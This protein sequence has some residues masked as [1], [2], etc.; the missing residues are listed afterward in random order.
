MSRRV[1]AC[2][3]FIYVSAQLS[4]ELDDFIGYFLTDSFSSHLARLFDILIF[5]HFH[6]VA[7]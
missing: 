4:V 1:T 6:T 2:L 3:S 7:K 5:N